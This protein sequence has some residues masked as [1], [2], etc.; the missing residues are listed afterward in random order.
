[1][2]LKC[3]NLEN[4]K[5][6]NLPIGIDVGAVSRV[7]LQRIMIDSDSWPSGRQWKVW[8]GL[9]TAGDARYDFHNF[10]EFGE[11]VLERF[12]EKFH[13]LGLCFCFVFIEGWNGE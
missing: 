5:P 4:T 3:E 6:T 12:G 11:F 1:M 2:D 9:K 13:G 7:D 10:F 8:I